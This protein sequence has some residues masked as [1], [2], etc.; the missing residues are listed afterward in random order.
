MNFS[1]KFRY[2]WCLNEHDAEVLLL[3]VSICMLWVKKTNKCGL[4]W[5]H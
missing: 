2:F 4:F 1:V 3:A 5:K